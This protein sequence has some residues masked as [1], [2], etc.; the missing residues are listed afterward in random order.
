M[1]VTH[2]NCTSRYKC[3]TEF[4]ICLR[5]HIYVLKEYMSLREVPTLK[6]KTANVVF[7]FSQ[8]SLLS[9]PW[10]SVG[11]LEVTGMAPFEKKTSIY[12][13]LNHSVASS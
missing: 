9:L 3:L 13:Q 11:F 5:D 4:L 1:H 2:K 7:F 8:I 12:F 10:G 6:K